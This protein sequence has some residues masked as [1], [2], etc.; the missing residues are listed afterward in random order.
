MDRTQFVCIQNGK[1][2]MDRLCRE[3]EKGKQKGGVRLK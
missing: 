1:S 3:V 2:V